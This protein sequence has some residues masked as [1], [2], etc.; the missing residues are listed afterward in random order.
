MR[1]WFLF[2]NL[3][4]W[5]K[6]EDGAGRVLQA[7]GGVPVGQL[8]DGVGVGAWGDPAGAFQRNSLAGYFVYRG[9]EK[10]KNQR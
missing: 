5:C 6:T 3:T 7:V 8:G 9:Q 2:S 4:A 10:A 1:I